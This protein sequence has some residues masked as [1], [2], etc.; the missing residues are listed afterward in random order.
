MKRNILLNPGPLTTS[1]AVKQAL[2]VPDICHREQEFTTLLKGICQDLLKVVQAPANAYNAVLF[3]SSGTGAVEAC[4]SSLIPNGKKLVVINNGAYG[5]RI[6]D[7]AKRYHIEVIEIAFDYS[8]P[9]AIEKIAAVLKQETN[10]AYLAMVHHETSSGILNPINAVGEVCKA[11]NCGFIVDAMSSFAGC[12]ID[13][14]KDN[15]DFL[16]SS[17]NK[18]LQGMPG[19]AFV[20]ANNNK[21]I[22]AK[23]CARSYYFDLWQQQ[24]TF[25]ATGQ[26]PFTPAVQVAYAMRQAL[27]ELF[28]ETLAGRIQRY[29]SNYACLL[30]GLERLGFRCVTPADRQ[31]HM[32]VTV[33]FPT[34][35]SYEF[36][37][38]HDYLYA[39]GFTIYPKKLDI[40]NTFRLA[41]I[42]DLYQQDITAFIQ[43]VAQYQQSR[44]TIAGTRV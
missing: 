43:A 4:V 35:H 44:P 3:T 34:T 6:I 9:L 29:H 30:A 12:E 24:Q 21:L 32:L 13:I 16:A 28:S 36:D 42:G 18:C 39:R 31:S 10:V 26:L 15:I 1:Q 20:I 8:E 11:A 17:A 40:A 2:L 27:D 7:M 33:Q 19:I 37:D 38:F 14:V 5:Q 25:A 22:A 41:C 23:N